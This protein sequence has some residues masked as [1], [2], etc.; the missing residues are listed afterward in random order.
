MISRE[1][2]MKKFWMHAN[3]A[4]WDDIIRSLVEGGHVAIENQGNRVIFIMPDKAV[5]EWSKHFAG[6]N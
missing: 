1:Q 3:S 6:K 4:E 2:F 5:D